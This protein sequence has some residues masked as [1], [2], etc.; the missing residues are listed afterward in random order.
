MR[1]PETLVWAERDWPI[2]LPITWQTRP[3]RGALHVLPDINAQRFSAPV[4]VVAFLATASSIRRLANL[5]SK[6]CARVTILTLNCKT[7][8]FWETLVNTY[9]V[10]ISVLS[11]L[12]CMTCKV[13][14]GS[15]SDA[16][17]FNLSP[18]LPSVRCNRS[19]QHRDGLH[20]RCTMS[21]GHASF[22]A[23]GTSTLMRDF[24]YCNTTQNELGAWPP[25]PCKCCAHVQL[26]VHGPICGA[27][28]VLDEMECQQ[29]NKSVRV[30]TRRTNRTHKQKRQKYKSQLRNL[31]NN[32]QESHIR[33][34]NTLQM[35]KTKG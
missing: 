21:R 13:P 29:D 1:C 18:H 14:H 19:E 8:L 17:T 25:P 34:V 2:P 23:H 11:H 31:E 28:K 24:W 35:V 32:G 33:V 6:L 27:D 5:N 4:I 30:T 26:G 22:F 20:L 3:F 16:F 15:L 7:L 9:H 12:G 10:L